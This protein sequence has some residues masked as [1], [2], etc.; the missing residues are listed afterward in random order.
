MTVGIHTDVL[1]VPNA[2]LTRNGDGPTV[3]LV[4]V[5]GAGEGTVVHI[6]SGY[7]DGLQTVIQEGLSEGDVILVRR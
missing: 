7:S 5:A 1:L 6:T 3:R 4:D 2:A